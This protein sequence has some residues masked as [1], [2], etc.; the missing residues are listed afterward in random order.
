MVLSSLSSDVVEL[1]GTHM[2]YQT[3]KN[4]LL[5]HKSLA[6]TMHTYT[7]QSWHMRPGQP[8]DKK[9]TALLKFKP[10]LNRLEIFISEEFDV[11]C[12]AEALEGLS[13]SVVLVVNCEECD[14]MITPLLTALSSRRQNVLVHGTLQSFSAFVDVME[15]CSL[16]WLSAVNTITVRSH[17]VLDNDGIDRVKRLA[18]SWHDKPWTITY[19][20]FIPE[21]PAYASL[22]EK[23]LLDNA[24]AASSIRE[25]MAR[26][27]QHL[28]IRIGGIP[29][30]L[31]RVAHMVYSCGY[32]FNS[33]GSVEFME[34]LADNPKL[35]TLVLNRWN[36]QIVLHERDLFNRVMKNG[37]VVLWLY[38][39]AIKD[40]SLCNM[41]LSTNCK[42]VLNVADAIGVFIVRRMADSVKAKISP[43]RIKISYT[44]AVQ[45]LADVPLV[46]LAAKVIE[47]ESPEVC[48]Y[49]NIDVV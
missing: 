37:Q 22:M 35:S 49:F 21:N 39:E 14:A 28:V 46:A 23:E 27:V 2:D 33:V 25:I 43:D 12:F 11:M 6:P 47:E 44:D 4:S 38:G 10:R 5:A 19:V 31:S 48:A 7:Y 40:P 18:K 36:S 16:G 30:L 20:E 32:M 15:H 9:T 8:F 45:S 34:D 24:D 13:S 17:I 42:L 26:C 41:V 3:R 1:I 29:T